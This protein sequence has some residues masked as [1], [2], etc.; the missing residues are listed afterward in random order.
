MVGCKVT[1]GHVITHTPW[2]QK[3]L[4]NVTSAEEWLIRR[5]PIPVAGVSSELE[6]AMEECYNE[7]VKKAAAEKNKA[8]KQK[9]GQKLWDAENLSNSTSRRQP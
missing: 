5:Q 7:E 2:I 8:P 9:L 6:I 1:W 4:F 3:R